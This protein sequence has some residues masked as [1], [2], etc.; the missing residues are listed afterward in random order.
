MTI[1]IWEADDPL[2]SETLKKRRYYR[3]LYSSVD[4]I[5]AKSIDLLE[6]FEK[7]LR[8]SQQDIPPEFRL[9]EEDFWKLV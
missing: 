5:V 2:I 7:K 8:A 4:P 1:E 6:E 9:S 3:N